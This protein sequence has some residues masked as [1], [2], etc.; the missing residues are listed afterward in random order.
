MVRDVPARK[1]RPN[2]IVISKPVIK[3]RNQRLPLSVLLINTR[4]VSFLSF[5]HSSST[6]LLLLFFLLWLWFSTSLLRTLLLL[7]LGLR[8]LHFFRLGVLLILL[9]KK[10]EEGKKITAIVFQGPAT[11]T[12]M[13]IGR[14][15][16]RK[17]R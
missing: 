15:T 11:G 12:V 16:K 6:L 1:R 5:F 13:G 2:E 4:L 10:K 14:V 3:N 17:Y 8:R 7:L 9:K